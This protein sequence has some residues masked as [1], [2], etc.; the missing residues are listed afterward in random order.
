MLERVGGTLL[1]V[2]ALIIGVAGVQAMAQAG[3][4]A[5]PTTDTPTGVPSAAAAPPTVPS[6]PPA[7]ASPG[8]SAATGTLPVGY[9]FLNTVGD[10]PAL[11]DACEPV[12]YTVDTSGAPAG[13]TVVVQAAISDA[14]N[15][16]GL[17]FQ[18]ESGDTSHGLVVSIAFRHEADDS[19]LSGDAIGVT[20]TRTTLTPGDPQITQAD[21]RLED[22]W[23]SQ[24]IPDTPDL[25][26]MVVLHEIGHALGL[27]HDNDPASIMYPEAGATKPTP[28]DRQ[29]FLALNAGCH[30]RTGHDSSPD[31][32]LTI[33]TQSNMLMRNWSRSTTRP[34][35]PAPKPPKHR[36]R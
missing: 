24:A 30:S 21:I 8:P 31:A 22:E 29:A 5:T 34:H 14:A 33:T 27:G 36:S 2:V 35:R 15:M 28:N 9:A 11:A 18:P 23:F 16:T 1:G 4:A 32:S 19:G 26:T 13:S 17:S 3:D 7:P 25:A 6:T 10:L 20:N 12:A